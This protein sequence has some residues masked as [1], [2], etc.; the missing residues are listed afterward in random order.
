MYP[1]IFRKISHPVQKIY[2]YW[3]NFSKE[4][5]QLTDWK[6]YKKFRLIWINYKF[7][8]GKPKKIFRK[9]YHPVQ[10]IYIYWPNFSKGVSQLTDWQT[11]KKFQIIWIQYTNIPGKPPTNFRR[12]SHPE[13]E[14]SLHLFNFSK[15][16]SQLTDCQTYKKFGMI[17]R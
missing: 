3:P 9:K 8:P 5:S 15:E 6:T 4:V 17:W 12:I 14:I 1:K 2:L 13:K 7:I 11:Y 10:E 16:V